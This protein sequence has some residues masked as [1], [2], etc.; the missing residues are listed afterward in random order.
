MT[1]KSASVSALSIVRLSVYLRVSG[2]GKEMS[3]VAWAAEAHSKCGVLSAQPVEVYGTAM[4][5]NGSTRHRQC[6]SRQCFQ[7]IVRLIV[8]LRGSANGEMACSRVKG[9]WP[10]RQRRHGTK[11]LP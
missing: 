4:A 3:S 6:F 11:A 2:K 9:R 7:S 1:G 10:R 5:K 8:C